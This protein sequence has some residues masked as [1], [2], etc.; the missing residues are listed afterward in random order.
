MNLDYECFGCGTR[1][2]ANPG[3]LLLLQCQG[4]VEQKDARYA[5]L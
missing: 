2:M 4:P 3:A 1:L 5:G